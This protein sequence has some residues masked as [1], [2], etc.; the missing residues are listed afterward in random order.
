LSDI[1]ISK[2]NLRMDI[3]LFNLPTEKTCPGSTPLCR[4]YCYSK[5]AEKYRPPVL[6]SRERNYRASLREDFTEKMMV[7]LE[8]LSGEYFRCHESGDMYNQSY[9]DKWFT[10]M[11]NSPDKT[12]IVYTQSYH[13]NWSDK[14]ENLVVY[15]SVWEDSK[16]VP[17][18]GLHAYVIDNGSGKLTAKAKPGVKVCEKGKGKAIKCNDCMYCYKGRGD[19]AFTLH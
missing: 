13:L 11:R 5:K 7:G 3:P 1:Y 12:F 18:D 16:N 15:W 19:V 4:Q 8:K 14:P 17:K 10:I 2:G 6:P 9:L